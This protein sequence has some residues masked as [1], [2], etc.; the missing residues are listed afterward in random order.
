MGQFHTRVEIR[1]GER[2]AD[3]AR[4]SASDRIRLAKVALLATSAGMTGNLLSPVQ[5]P[6]ILY[7]LK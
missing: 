7:A 3:V 4:N 2:G 5:D 1:R 6:R